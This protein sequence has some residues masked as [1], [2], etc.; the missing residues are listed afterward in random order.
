MNRAMRLAALAAF[1][2]AGAASA[3]TLIHAGRLIDGVSAAP[4]ERVTVVVDGGRIRAVENG[5]RAAGGGD[6]VV[7]L[8]RRRCCR[9][10]WTCT[11]T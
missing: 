3:A 9:V 5:F 1:L 11:C 7:D 10:S 8:A 4:R 2:P 6:E